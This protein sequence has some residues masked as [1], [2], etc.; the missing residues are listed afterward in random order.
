MAASEPQELTCWALSFAV[1]ALLARNDGA[2]LGA[3]GSAAFNCLGA[4]MV[5]FW[6]ASPPKV[7]HINSTNA[8]AAYM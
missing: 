5:A 4:M 1:W 2:E 8:H 3:S 6:F 7:S